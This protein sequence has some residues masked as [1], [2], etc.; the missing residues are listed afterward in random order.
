SNED[1]SSGAEAHSPAGNLG[2][3]AAALSS[4]ASNIGPGAAALSSPA[5]GDQVKTTQSSGDDWKATCLEVD[6]AYSRLLS[7]TYKTDT[8][9][10]LL[11]CDEWTNKL[12]QMDVAA[13]NFT[14]SEE[15]Y[16]KIGKIRDQ[17]QA[18]ATT[19]N[20]SSVPVYSTS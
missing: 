1:L 12:C 4:P 10:T 9:I 19:M 15:V 3:S 5:G 6:Y 14:R 17:L 16:V 13:K 20:T 8:S 2:L 7:R 18:D 11:K